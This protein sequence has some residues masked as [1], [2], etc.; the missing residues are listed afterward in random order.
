[1]SDVSERDYTADQRADF[2]KKGW[3]L[4]DGSFPIADRVDLLNAIRAIGRAKD[5]AAA[6]RHIIKRAKALGLTD[7]LPDDWTEESAPAGES[8]PVSDSEPSAE[9]AE[10]SA[11]AAPKT[12][13]T[14]VDARESVRLDW[15]A[16]EGTSPRDNRYRML[17]I[18][19]GLSLNRNLW[20]ESVLSAAASK[21]DGRPI[22]LNHQDDT[23]MEA[24][25]GWWSD[26]EYVTNLQMS[27]GSAASGIVATANFFENSA[28][29][30]VPAMIREAIERGVPGLIGISVDAEVRGKVAR[31][32]A[33]MLYRDIEEIVAFHSADVVAEPGAGGRP[34][35]VIT[36]GICTDEELAMLEKLTLE[37]LK[38][39]RPDLYNALKENAPMS[40]E[41]VTEGNDTAPE[42]RAS[43][44][45]SV[46]VE[47]ALKA[48]K[49]LEEKLAL[50]EQ[51]AAVER[52]IAESRIPAPVAELIRAEVGNTLRT[53]EELDE[54]FSRVLKALSAVSSAPD[55]RPSF[56]LGPIGDSQV[57]PLD[58]AIAA[59][60]EWFGAPDE[61]MKGKYHPIDSIRQFY[62]MLTG[63]R[64]VDGFY[65]PR[66]SALGDYLGMRV[67]EALPN[68]ANIIGG[69]TITLPYIFGLSMNRA[70][71]KM[72]R[73]QNRWWEPI[74]TKTRL[75]NFKEQQRV[76]MHQFGS[77]T[78]RPVGTEEYT[79]LTY[80]ETQETFTPTGFGHV[81][82]VGRRAIIN[83]DLESI[84]RIPALLAQSATYTINERVANLFLANSGAGVTLAD[85]YT[86]FDATNHQGNSIT[87]AL[88]AGS[89]ANAIKIA[90]R[91]TNQAG[92]RIGW[93]LRYLLIPIDLIDT[94]YQITAADLIPGSNNNDPNFI[95]SQWGIPTQNVIVVPQFTDPNNWYALADPSDIA[96]IEVGFVLGREEPELFVQDAENTGTVFTH[97]VMMFK[98][99][100]EYG[101]GVLDYRG[102][103]ASIVA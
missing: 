83:D 10:E 78:A 3:A 22:Y 13:S 6:K 43:E 99:R 63:D 35:A 25:I 65:N 98:V 7:L 87:S 30:W 37:E 66:E 102:S 58:Q 32:E 93:Q 26:P 91:M 44:S 46:A 19:P 64:N 18:R 95:K 14:T 1:M 20:K 59:L 77:L 79:E 101:M 81:V 27:D 89:L 57:T 8:E 21:L 60:Q 2:A 75:S 45:T 52:R 73:G 48:V 11:P 47:E 17:V 4:P 39:A 38:E 9:L 23:L 24:K 34:V 86:W 85:T 67:T 88:S 12:D 97:D 53:A 94:A 72:Y 61:T 41:K 31:D 80:G 68:Q 71:Q 55:A 103:V 16:L 62:V 96:I 69:S 82:S 100:H 76:I 70:L 51:A 42:G 28:H 29:P 50:K 49:T 15:V 90:G 92:K 56:P 74:V 40:E 33:G 36:E 84:R 5:P 54:I